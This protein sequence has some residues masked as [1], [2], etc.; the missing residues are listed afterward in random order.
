MILETLLGFALLDIDM[1]LPFAIVGILNGITLALT[2][3]YFRMKSL[4]AQGV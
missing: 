1:R 4:R 3:P 2:V